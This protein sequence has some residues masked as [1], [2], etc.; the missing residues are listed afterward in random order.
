M[1][2]KKFFKSIVNPI[3]QGDISVAEIHVLLKF[4]LCVGKLS[5]KNYVNLNTNENMRVSILF[6]TSEKYLWGLYF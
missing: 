4:H 2:E 6:I 1:K 5:T 3:T